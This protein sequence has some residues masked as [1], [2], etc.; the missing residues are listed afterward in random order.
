ME[1]NDIHKN[2]GLIADFMDA[3]YNER[4]DLV[5]ID[6]LPMVPLDELAF[7]LSWDWLIPVIDKITS[8]D[9]YS[10]FKDYTS[11]MVSKGEIDIN[12]RFIENTWNDVVDFIKW[13]NGKDLKN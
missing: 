5:F 9:E 3:K 6:G 1:T 4:V 10:D 13:Y 2:N 12:T 7:H 11:S 8:M